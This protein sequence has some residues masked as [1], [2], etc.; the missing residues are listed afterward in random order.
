MAVLSNL[1]A[2]LL[3]AGGMSRLVGGTQ[4]VFTE[5]IG[6][7]RL[8]DATSGVLATVGTGWN[9]PRAV[10]A[11]A[12]NLYVSDDDTIVRVEVGAADRAAGT[13][14]VT[15]LTVPHQL[16][17]SN[18]G[19][20][21]YVV[22]FDSPGRLLRLDLVAG[23]STVVC[24]TLE[25]PTG[26]AL[27]PDGAAAYVTEHPVGGGRL[28]VVDLATGTTA[29]VLDGLAAPAYLT[30]AGLDALL[31]VEADPA[32]RLLRVDLNTTGI[33][34][35]AAGLPSGAVHVVPLETDTYLLACA[36]EIDRVFDDR[37]VIES[38]NVMQGFGGSVLE[39]TGRNFAPLREDN[40][41]GIGGRVARV[42]AADP[43]RLS[44]LADTTTRSGQ[45]TVSTASGTVTTPDTFGVLPYPGGGEDGPP[46]VV[47]GKGAG[48]L[49]AIPPTGNVKVLVSLVFPHDNVPGNQATARASIVNSW[50]SVVTYYKQV[51]FADDAS[52]EG[53][54]VIPTVTASWHELSGNQNDYV[55]L[56]TADNVVDEAKPRLEAEAAQAAADEGLVL[57]EFAVLETV[58]W[59][60]G[61]FI[62]GYGGSRPAQN[63]TF[64]GQDTGGNDVD[65]DI[66]VD[67]ELDVIG[68]GEDAD[69]GRH[70][71]ELGHA[72]VSAPGGLSG[73]LG[74]DIY[75]TGLVDPSDASAQH[76]DL[77]GKHDERP[78]FSAFHMEALGWYTALESLEWDRNE[79]SEQFTVASHGS[80]KTPP[81]GS[82]HLVKITVA[83]GLAYYVEARSR[84]GASGQLYDLNIPAADDGSTAGAIV[85]RVISGEVNNNQEMR[86]IT[87]LHDSKLLSIGDSAL[88][89]AR[90]LTITV[91]G[92]SV[93][94]DTT[95]VKVTVAWAQG[96]ADDPNGAFDLSIEPWNGGYQTPDIWVDR[97]PFSTFD[98]P[99][100]SEG[101]P[102]GVGDK[103]RVDAINHLFARVHVS[104]TVGATNVPV[105]FYAVTPVVVGDN[106]AWTPLKTVTV[107][108]IPVNGFADVQTN[109]VPIVDEHSCVKVYISQ[110]LGEITGDNNSAQENVTEFEAAS[111]SVPAAVRMP[112]AVRNPQPQ[113][114]AVLVSLTG[115]PL[116]FIAQI[117]HSWVWLDG[118][119]A[120]EMALTIIATEDFSFYLERR[121]RPAPIRVAGFIERVYDTLAIGGGGP[122]AS[123]L[124]PIGGVLAKVTPKKL[125]K[126]ELDQKT[127]WDESGL[128]RVRGHIQPPWQGERVTV[129]AVD[130]TQRRYSVRVTT[131]L[132]GQFGAN[133]LTTNVAVQLRIVASVEASPSV[134][135]CDS[136]PL[137]LTR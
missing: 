112:F 126:I 132:N 85:T 32:R 24:A 77:M 28:T 122:V 133:I 118:N 78:L 98:N 72:L 92:M 54:T 63:F 102:T 55:D 71:H 36:S 23:T 107:P 10:V 56:V 96:I 99:P 90:D 135:E 38:V 6:S 127:R 68:I 81:A 82:R 86:F 83:T 20:A 49:Y 87:L 51:S 70:A 2:G 17:L 15:G 66:S 46:V 123:R 60:N 11:D 26:L 91:D 25:S 4:I 129:R 106:D 52:A 134:V 40:Q 9:F 7:L 12:T 18:D 21:L 44:V 61:A 125:G 50:D 19:K 74:E 42:F 8:I 128:V 64:H 53:L 111:S 35:V 75:D 22:E 48:D 45:L 27:A 84:T 58:I 114:R 29:L 30:W 97:E 105:T 113:R 16:S 41:V 120:R 93:S 100:D 33:D 110:Q 73:V 5:Q 67:H 116:G 103:P 47:Q 1:Q 101:R 43:T 69:W 39:L 104:G 13:E 37:P 65:I 80:S 136:P 124:L 115:V 76:F 95:L 119:E 89:P 94:G 59:L 79:K 130:N 108:S 14:L 34:E 62:R 3:G 31:L 57:D 117:P 131:A 109:W 121:L 88:D 137:T